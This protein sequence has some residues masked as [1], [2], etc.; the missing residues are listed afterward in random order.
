MSTVVVG[1]GIA[2]LVAARELLRQGEVVDLYEASDHLGGLVVPQQMGDIVV[3]GG[4]DAFALRTNVVADL[5]EEL[6][7]EIAESQGQPHI[8]WPEAPHRWPMA[9][10]VLGIPASLDDPALAGA[11]TRAELAEA[12]R[13]LKMG[14]D[15]AADETMLGPLVA[16]RLGRAVVERLV[17][18]VTRGVY[19]RS[20]DDI[21]V[22]RVIPGLRA[23]LRE[24]GSLVAAVA[25]T[26]IPGA[27]AVAQPVGGLFRLVEELAA[28][29]EAKGGRIHTG[30]VVTELE[31]DGYSWEVRTKAGPLRADRVLL[32]VGARAAA[33]L[34]ELLGVSFEVPPTHPSSQAVLSL[35]HPEI[36]EGPVGS[37]VI[38]G[39]RDPRLVAQALTHYSL[40]W[41]WAAQTGRHVLRLAYAA[42]PTMG[43]AL[44]DASLLMG[45]KL[46]ADD[47][48]DFAVLDLEMPSTMPPAVHTLL[49]ENLSR[50]DGLAVT[51][52]WVAGNSIAAVVHSAQEVVA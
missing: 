25:A 5:C 47:V 1:G 43:Q 46:T 35:N 52:A 42:Q 16:A 9:D 3:D 45:V 41:P 38:E 4:A 13:D 12:A 32:A 31:H 36:G 39:R 40:K 21:A 48:V 27:A 44:A 30:H 7:L 37:G 17:E 29:V 20:P 8:W 50:F 51:G 11:L 15:V 14:G 23:A 10:G 22:D 18:P 49:L 33:R 2:G 6:G 24:H 19:G 26:R 34:L 28:D